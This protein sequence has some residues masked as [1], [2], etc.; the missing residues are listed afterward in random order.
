M[1]SPIIF[2]DFD[3]VLNSLRSCLVYGSYQRFDPISCGLVALLAANTDAKVVVSSSWRI[4]G[5]VPR[6][7]DDLTQ[8]GPE[9][10]AIAER[11]V[12]MTPQLTGPRGAEIAAWL[13]EHA[14]GPEQPYVIIDD[15]SDMLD[16]QLSRFVQ[17]S[18][19]DGFGVPEY[20]KAMSILSPEHKDSNDLS[21]LARWPSPHLQWE[22]A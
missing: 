8:Q 1:H 13:A 12:S 4:G 15:D 3:G 17:T 22:D 5:D 19:R 18:H 9:G 6:L 2:L 14:P 10:E 20:H 7:V 16:G 21:S 11:V